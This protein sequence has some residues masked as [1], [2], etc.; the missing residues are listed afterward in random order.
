MPQKGSC[1]IE[2][3]KYNK[4]KTS[5]VYISRFPSKAHETRARNW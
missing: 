1:G 2:K 4:S 3:Y 5:I